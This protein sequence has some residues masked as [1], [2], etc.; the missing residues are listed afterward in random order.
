MGSGVAT[1]FPGRSRSG[2]REPDSGPCPRE[3]YSS[4]PG[5]I[6]ASLC[7]LLVLAIP[8]IM[9]ANPIDPG[10]QAGWYDDGDTDQ[11][12][13]QTLSPESMI[14]LA[15]LSFI[16]LSVYLLLITGREPRQIDGQG[17]DP[18]PRGPPG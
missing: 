16:S 14:G 15:V 10:W 18:V 11:L 12:V 17:I 2:S 9:A 8:V 5:G 13:T 3:S 1:Y 7:A 6:C 4:S